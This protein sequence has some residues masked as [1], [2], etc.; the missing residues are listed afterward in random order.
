MIRSE[1]VIVVFGPTAV[2]K[3]VFIENLFSRIS[4]IEIINADSMQVY[5]YMNV[6]MAKPSDQLRER[7][8]HHLID[9][10]EPTFQFNAGE[11]VHR[12]E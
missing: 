12:A 3:T 2:G 6:G 9:V 7:I 10:V 1:P 8:P 4:N 11:F 5:R